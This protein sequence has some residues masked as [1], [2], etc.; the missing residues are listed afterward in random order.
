[1]QIIIEFKIIVAHTA[2]EMQHMKKKKSQHHI[3]KKM[4]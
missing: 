1:M 4:I 3:Q 2:Y